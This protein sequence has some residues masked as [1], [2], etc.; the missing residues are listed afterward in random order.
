MMTEVTAVLSVTLSLLELPHPLF[1]NGL[2]L[3]VFSTEELIYSLGF[4]FSD[5]FGAQLCTQYLVLVV[6]AGFYFFFLSAVCAP[7]HR[8]IV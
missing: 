1:P 7:C 8:K 3:C 5:P 2:S 4:L 6:L